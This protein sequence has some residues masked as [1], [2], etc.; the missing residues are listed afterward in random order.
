MKKL[1]AGLIAVVLLTSAVASRA[2]AGIIVLN[3]DEWTLSTTGFGNSPPGSA[4]NFV[5]NIANTFSGG[6]PGNFLIYSNNFGL[7]N[8]SLTGALTANGSSVSQSTNAADFTLANLLN[9][10]GVFLGGSNSANYSASVLAAYVNAGGNVYLAGGTGE[11]GGSSAAEANAWNPFLNQFGLGFSPVFNGVQNTISIPN[12]IP[13]PIF[14]N[15]QGLFFNNGND[16]L[17]INSLDPQGRV[18]LT[19]NGHGLIALY[20]SSPAVPEPASII[21]WSLGALGGAIGARRRSNQAQNR[22]AV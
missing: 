22:A 17:D 9:Y 19:Q 12:P 4:A 3:N 20:E 10:D 1:V 16:A 15:V 6:G 11:F 21:L 14:Q 5:H 2:D 7:N 8:S 18:V 13:D